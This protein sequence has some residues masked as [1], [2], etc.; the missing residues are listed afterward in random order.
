MISIALL[1]P[2]YNEADNIRILLKA[3]LESF[4]LE[5]GINLKIFVIDDNS[6]DGTS[7]VVEEI[8]IKEKCERL[9]IAVIRRK[10]KNGL[11]KA[12]IDGINR[13]LNLDAFDYVLQMDA[14]LSHD[15]IYLKEFFL[16]AKESV[17]LGVGSRYVSGGGVPDW[18]WHRKFLSKFG[19]IYARAL[20]GSGITDYT[21]GYNLYSTK[22][23][24]K[25]DLTQLDSS[26]YGFL[27]ALKFYSLKNASKVKQI[28]IV[29]ID[30]KV[31]E[32]KMPMN[33]LVKNLLLVFRLWRTR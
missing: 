10:E 3:I 33:T 15:A 6:P 30:R 7:D 20:L 18:A 5:N 21:G 14:D 23:L 31:G 17:D 1:I 2:T 9:E 4:K 13:V 24:K 12:Y 16:A 22:L 8:S 28:P 11:G 27:I 29:F 32:S 25:I 26:G 19:N